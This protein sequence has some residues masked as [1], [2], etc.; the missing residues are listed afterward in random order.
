MPD[1]KSIEVLKTV[2]L[3]RTALDG[4]EE[5]YCVFDE[6][7]LLHSWNL[8][9]E[10]DIPELIRQL[11]PGM[12]YERFLNASIGLGLTEKTQTAS[13][14]ISG[15][16][17]SRLLGDEDLEFD[18]VLK[19]NRWI[20]ISRVN[21][22]GKGWLIIFRNVMNLQHEREA[23][24]LSEEKFKRFARLASNWFW[25][26]DDNL[27]YLYHST[28]EGAMFTDDV[29]LVAG[30][31]R[32][33]SLIGKANENAQLRKHNACLLA[34][35]NVN[36]VLSWGVEGSENITYSHVLAEPRYN[37]QGQFIGYI[38]CGR[39]VTATHKMSA[40]YEY[41]AN[42]DHLTGLKNRR[43]FE[44]YLDDVAHTS[45][46][47]DLEENSHT[48]KINEQYTLLSIDLDRF[49]L[50]NDDVGHA[51]GD[52]LL[53]QVSRLL[54]QVVGDSGLVARVG[55][56]EF[57]VCLSMG[58]EEAEPLVDSLLDQI[59]NSTFKWKNRQFSLGAS[60]GLAAFI[61]GLMNKSVLMKNA[62]VA[63]Y[64]AKML[65]RNRKEVFSRD[66]HFQTQ[67]SVEVEILRTLRSAMSDDRLELYLQPIVTAQLDDHA[68]KYEVLL[69]LID[70]QGKI[71]T[72]NTF[73]PTAE[74]YDV[75]QQV[76]LLVVEKS[77]KTLKEFIDLGADVSFSIN[78]SGKT[79]GSERCLQR[80]VALVKE[81]SLPANS[82]CFEI[83]ETAAINSL[84]VVVAFMDELKAFGC[85]FSLDDFGSGLSSYS[86]L[87]SLNVDYIKIDGSFIKKITSEKASQAI[88]KS[89]NTLSHEMGMKTVAEFVENK[90]IADSVIAMNIDY[91]QGYHYGKPVSK[92]ELLDLYSMSFLKTGTN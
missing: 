10:S 9:L 61:P 86:Y 88:V 46:I 27:C 67:Q 26:L 64:S 12:E 16:E 39:D 36:V 13:D 56:D 45:Q 18:L 22:Q 89:I 33:D 58:V 30:L 80:I 49:K 59:S 91:L 35:E 2:Q 63:C 44:S 78:L 47:V 51:A 37:S 72:P 28:H 34:H 84:E 4:R 55:G 23:L 65:G 77:I 8:S 52:Q 66:N 43:A 87:E 11:K 31:S 69:R 60:A 17:F 29:T 81:Q 79:L 74:K 82:L 50:I 92:S 20:Q 62:D 6:A 15:T 40:E 25:E 32:I 7:G 73:I 90:D 57:G 38:G 85:Q 75:M 24:I 19:D 76:D 70:V 1:S 14:G 68:D 21:L 53:I 71:I 5:G 42:H 54:E 3:L 83:T 41:Q 48:K